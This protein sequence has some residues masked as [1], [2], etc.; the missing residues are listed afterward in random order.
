MFSLKY[1]IIFLLQN[2]YFSPLNN[3]MYSYN[4]II[5][6]D[7]NMSFY[8]N[9][10]TFSIILPENFTDFWQ[11]HHVKLYVRA[12]LINYMCHLPFKGCLT[13]K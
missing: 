3:W 12:S 5:H 11:R 10:I 13:L 6:L 2:N 4:N 1:I 9:C 8:E 7:V